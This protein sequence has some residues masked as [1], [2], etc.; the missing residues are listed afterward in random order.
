MI[1]I[2]INDKNKSKNNYP[3]TL[4]RI[5]TGCYASLLIRGFYDP[6]PGFL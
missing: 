4:I 3:E 5:A 1:K 2:Y 6:D